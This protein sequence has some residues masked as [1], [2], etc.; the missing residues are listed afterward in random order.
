MT[1]ASTL[2][3]GSL[4]LGETATP[5][6]FATQLTNA[7]LT[8]TFEKE[9]DVAT[10]DGGNLPGLDTETW[11]L[12]G[13]LLQDYE[14]DSLEDWCFDNKS[15]TVPFVFTPSSA[16]YRSYSGTCKI[17]AL[18]VGGAVKTRNTADFTFPVIGS[19]TPGVIV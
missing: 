8:P 5:R 4:K 17:R 16:G 3:P 2:G 9:D 1:K 11:E 10:L 18:P 7:L 15:L 6:E 14:M 13:T 19:P 12:S